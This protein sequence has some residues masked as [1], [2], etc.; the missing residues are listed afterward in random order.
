MSHKDDIHDGM[1]K[2]GGGEQEPDP[3][4]NLVIP[5]GTHDT[6]TDSEFDKGA[7]SGKYQNSAIG[8]YL[9]PNG[10]LSTVQQN[11]GVSSKKVKIR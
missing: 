6:V 8:L 3:E 4:T 7:A 1:R 5:T 2:L 10:T 11:R 9:L